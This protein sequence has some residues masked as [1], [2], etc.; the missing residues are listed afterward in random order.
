MLNSDLT[1]LVELHLDNNLEVLVAG[2]EIYQND[3]CKEKKI[4]WY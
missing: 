2:S 3:R 1:I 4:I